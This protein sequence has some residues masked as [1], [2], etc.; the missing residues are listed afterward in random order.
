MSLVLVR[1]VYLKSSVGCQTLVKTLVIE[2]HVYLKASNA[3]LS[4]APSERF[5]R[6]SC[7]NGAEMILTD[8]FS[9]ATVRVRGPAR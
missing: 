3:A 5:S 7:A 1:H 2:W 4:R 9:C 8:S 6:Q